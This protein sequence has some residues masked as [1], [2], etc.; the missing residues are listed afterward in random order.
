MDNKLSPNKGRVFPISEKDEQYIGK[1][2]LSGKLNIEYWAK[3]IDDE[4]EPRCVLFKKEI[5]GKRKLAVFIEV[6][7]LHD[8]GADVA[9]GKPNY[10]GKI[11]QQN[12]SAYKNK[13]QNGAD[14]MGLSVYTPNVDTQP[15]ESQQ[16]I[17]PATVENG[18][19]IDDD[20]PF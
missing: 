5:N 8:N 4:Y 13:S 16:A 20:I 11:G 9:E 1:P 14:Y 15:S 2:V 10:G 17:Q 12:I 3:H 18:G 7:L 19:T 6:G